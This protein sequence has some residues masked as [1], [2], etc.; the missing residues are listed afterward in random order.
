ML[1]EHSQGPAIGDDHQHLGDENGLNG[2]GK[3]ETK[4]NDFWIPNVCSHFKH[5]HTTQPLKKNILTTLSTGRQNVPHIHHLLRCDFREQE[6]QVLRHWI[7]LVGS[8]KQTVGLQAPVLRHWAQ[9]HERRFYHVEKLQSKCG[10]NV[11]FWWM[12]MTMMIIDI[13]RCELIVSL[14][15]VLRICFACQNFICLLIFLTCLVI[16]N[17]QLWPTLPDVL[18]SLFFSTFSILSS[19]QKCSKKTPWKLT[20]KRPTRN[21]K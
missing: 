4:T 2:T 10:K 21:E 7:W 20:P 9:K 12:M 6:G 8:W 18:F 14:G 15:T 1:R 13:E 5:K 3:V 16:R 17:L 11:F 19:Q